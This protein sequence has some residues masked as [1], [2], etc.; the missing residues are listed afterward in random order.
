MNGGGLSGV[1][2]DA[3]SPPLTGL[4]RWPSNVALLEFWTLTSHIRGGQGSSHE[5]HIHQFKK[6]H[7]RTIIKVEAYIIFQ[8]T[9]IL[10]IES[11]FFS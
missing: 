2:M 3:A 5:D 11:I 1:E 8:A 4:P 7:L 6:I 9:T 10:S